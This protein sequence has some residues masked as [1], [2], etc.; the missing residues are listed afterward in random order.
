M[1]A[2]RNKLITWVQCIIT[3]RYDHN[4]HC[5]I[6]LFAKEGD[7]RRGYSLVQFL[8]SPRM[9]KEHTRINTLRTTS[10]TDKPN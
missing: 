6:S 8:G 2:T 9:C 7:L 4:N 3:Y 10:I 5:V 1:R